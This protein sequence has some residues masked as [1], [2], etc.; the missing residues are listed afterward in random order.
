MYTP[1][2]VYVVPLLL[3]MLLFGCPSGTSSDSPGATHSITY[4][5]NG[6]TSGSPPTDDSLYEEDAQV[7]VLGNTGNLARAWYEFTGWNTASGGGG[8]AYTAG[9]TFAMGGADVVLYAAWENPFLPSD[10][11]VASFQKISDTEGG[12]SGGLDDFDGFSLV[13]S[14][15]DL[16]GDGVADLAVG[17]ADDDG[18]TDR[19]A[20]WIL[21]LNSDGTVKS[22]QKIS[23]SEGGFSGVL[24][25]EDGFGNSI[26][27]PGDLDGDGTSDLVVGA[28]GDDDGGAD[29]GA[30][31]VLFMN[32]DG[33][34]K[35]HQKIS[36]TDGGF[37]GVL[38]DEDY[39]GTSVASL[40]DLDA[41]GTTDL[42]VGA[43]NDDDGGTNRG[44]VWI[45]FMN[46][47]GT[48]KS[49]QKISDTEGD[50][51]GTLDDSDRIGISVASPGD[52][53]DDGVVD[54]AAGA[55]FDDDGGDS[56]GAVWILFLNSDGTVASHRKI[57]DTEGGFTGTLADFYAFGARTTG[58]GDLDEDGVEDLLVGGFLD[59]DGGS[60][61]GAV[62]ILFMNGDGTVRSHQKISD[63][64]G[65]FAGVLEDG[66]FFGI[67]VAP[68]GDIDG[69]GVMDLAVGAS[70][71][72][73]DGTDRGAVWVLFLDEAE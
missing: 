55:D 68:L 41:D 43:V 38:D 50:F 16:D 3:L 2:L 39:Y 67:G 53:N 56:R 7:T 63:T 58:M 28:P 66:D 8:E 24:D 40:G 30:V 6:A 51:T 45:L 26:A 22:H 73:D 62:W 36:D 44:A 42:A 14:P 48:V 70:G 15:G 71:D 12:F 60:V 32:N 4:D 17:A 47:D 25:D 13:F 69:D 49:H 37:S 59:N 11:T 72:D 21:F 64:E 27:S 10:G 34:V 20:V 65:G 1:L 31:W 9:D 5:A 33:T 19:G 29:R 61:R 46:S 54:L 57:S 35:G 18:G 52:L 23:D